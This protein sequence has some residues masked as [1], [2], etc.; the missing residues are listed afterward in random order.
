[1]ALTETWSA[2]SETPGPHPMHAPQPGEMTS[3]PASRKMASKPR[4]R[5]WSRTSVEPYC[6][7][8]VTPS[9]TLRPAS[10]ASLSTAA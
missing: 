8:I 7:T 2:L 5:A 4:S 6:T 1:M 9:A 3:T 10:R